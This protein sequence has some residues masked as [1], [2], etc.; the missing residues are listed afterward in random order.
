VSSSNKKL[1]A[2]GEQA[3]GAE[4]CGEVLAR[5][6]TEDEK[7]L[8]L[9]ALNLKRVEIASG[10]VYEELPAAADMARLVSS[11]FAYHIP[12]ISTCV[13]KHIVVRFMK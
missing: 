5:G 8:I 9:E 6:L 13:I 4:A 3:A 7:L 11:I 2:A 12:N 1:G 10:I